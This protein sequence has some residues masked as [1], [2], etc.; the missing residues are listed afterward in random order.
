MKDPIKL[1]SVYQRLLSQRASAGVRAQFAG[2]G[3]ALLLTTTVGMGV[4][5]A[6]AS[7]AFTSESTVLQE[8]VVDLER[9]Y[10]KP[11]ILRSRYKVETRFNDAKV[12]YLLED[13][14]RSSLLFVGLVE[15]PK[16]QTQNT[17]PEALYLLADSLYLQRNLVAARNY[18]EQLINLGDGPYYQVAVVKLLELSARTGNYEGVDELYATLDAKA[19]LNPAV[20]YVRAKVLYRQGRLADARRL[21]Q[22]AEEDPDLSMRAAYYRGVAFVAD[23]QIDNGR[24]VF[25]EIIANYKPENPAQQRILDL[26]YLGAG[27]V[28]YETK[29]YPSAIDF[30]QHLDRNSPYFDQMLYE[31]TWTLVAQEKYEA[32]SRVTDIFMFLSNPDPAFVPKVR[33]LRA[34]LQL[35]LGN[36]DAAAQSYNDVVETFMPLKRELDEFVDGSR[37][38]EVFFS[39]LVES[40][41][42]GE[43]SDY[44]P[45]LVAEWVE[46]SPVLTKAKRAGADLGEIREQIAEAEH[47]IAEMDA[48]LASGA[49]IQSFPQLAEGMVLAATL[50]TRIVN[51]RQEMVNAEYKQAVSKMSPAQKAEWERLEREA[52]LLRAQYKAAPSTKSEVEARIARIDSRFASMRRELD[53]ITFELDSQ[54]EQLQAIETY[55]AQNAGQ[56]MSEERAQ[57][58][59]ELQAAARADIKNLRELQA[60]LRARI[61][62]ERQRLGVGDQVTS[63]ESQV[64]AS[65]SDVLAR[66]RSLIS[67]AGGGTDGADIRVARENLAEAE[68]RLAGFSAQM[69]RFVSERSE[70]L[71]EDLTREMQL[72]AQLDQTAQEL[73]TNSKDLTANVA[74]HSF[75]AAQHDFNQIIMR[76]DIGLIDVAWQK[77]EDATRQINQLF[78][79]RTAELKTLQDAFE[80]V[81]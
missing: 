34:D 62:V 28:A 51:L 25:E 53:T 46:G 80:E 31:L 42:R 7:R 56:P 49:R 67:Q 27:R 15:D 79:D 66:Q 4:A 39:D 37:D 17:Y 5:N 73:L 14:S 2:V 26:A 8:Q 64:R 16:F 48:R 19:K 47:A 63:K 72:L 41:M 52:E 50:E 71:L 75:L 40:Q 81:R 13:Y 10:L 77:K 1:K 22:K 44:M 58:I 78:E 24:Q 20:N 55:L 61:S 11:A 76:G 59:T 68:S 43:E 69:D 12:A 29:D 74:H 18:F 57:K 45:A 65:Y 60:A 38:L 6:Q 21:F 35:R 30:Y 32:A 70:E 36:Y 23:E 54:K 3:V 9:K 33:L